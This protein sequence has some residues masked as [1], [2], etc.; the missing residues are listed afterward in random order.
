MLTNKKKV[1]GGVIAAVRKIFESDKS[2]PLLKVGSISVI[3]RIV[4][5]FQ[6][7]GVYPIV[8]VTGYESY[9][10]ERDLASFGVIF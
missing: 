2:E 5:T 10:I 3:K 8:V 4:L 1:T 7:A 6:R 9:E